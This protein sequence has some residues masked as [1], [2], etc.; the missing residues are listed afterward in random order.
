MF[1]RRSGI[2][3]PIVMGGPWATANVSFA[4]TYNIADFIVT[5]EGERVFQELLHALQTNGDPALIDGIAVRSGDN[6]E[7]KDGSCTYIQ[8]VDDLPFPAWQKLPSSK[9]YFFC[10]RAFPFFPLLTSRGF[11]FDCVHCTKFIHGYKIR[12]RSPQNVL[13]EIEWLVKNFHARELL[14]AD[15]NFTM[16]RKHCIE[17]LK[18]IVKRGLKVKLNFGNGVRADTITPALVKL[19]RLAGTWSVAIGVESGNQQIVTTIGKAIKLEKVENAARLLKAEGIFLRAYFILGLPG[20]TPQT[21]QQTIDFA[22]HLD[23]DYAHFYIATIF[24]GT[25][26]HDEYVNL[27]GDNINIFTSFYNKVSMGSYKGFVDAIALSHA[28]RRAYMSYYLRPVKLAHLV[29]KFRSRQEFRYM[30]NFVLLELT[31]IFKK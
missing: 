8:D 14:I 6:G 22:K 21:M 17:I 29:S 1:I 25:K 27:F 24:P 9:K 12:L 11:P 2:Q 31:N 20:D 26:M 18:G 4:L 19:M 10:N 15:D 16:N 28:Y 3:V 7:I 5:G 23:A 13:D 30:F